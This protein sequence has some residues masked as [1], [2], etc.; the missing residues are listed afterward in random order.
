[1]AKVKE[2]TLQFG[3]P[4]RSRGSLNLIRNKY[5]TIAAKWPRKRGKAKSGYLFYR[6]WEFGIVSRWAAN[7]EPIARQ[8]ADELVKGTDLVWRDMFVQC[9]FGSLYEIQFQDGTPTYRYRDVVPNAQLMLDQVTDTIGSL[10]Y[11]AQ[12]GWVG[13]D[14]GSNNFV[15]TMRSGLPM[16]LPAQGGGGGGA[17]AELVTTLGAGTYIVDPTKTQ[18]QIIAIAGAG[19]GGGG[20][21]SA[22]ATACSGGGGGGGAAIVRTTFQLA[23][24]TGNISFVIG[25]GGGGGAGG[26]AINSNGLAGGAGT[27]TTFVVNGRTY[28]ASPG[29]GGVGGSTG[30]AGGG[31]ASVA[32]TDLGG[33]GGG[34]TAGAAGGSA[35]AVTTLGGTGGGAG[36][37]RT[38][39]GVGGNGGDAGRWSSAIGYPST[40]ALGGRVTPAALPQDGLLYRTLGISST[41]GGGG[42]G[43]T[44]GTGQ[45]GGAGGL[46]GGGGGGGA[47]STNGAP[48]GAGGAGGQGAILFIAT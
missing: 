26:A 25:G 18:L 27:A 6:Q 42:A 28:T 32:G 8:T 44:G 11:R 19:G 13:L 30:T 48:G 31:A 21:Q 12:I 9:S 29:G 20:R 15:L 7:P 35:P 46:F 3:A 17:V 36:S 41:G 4:A 16:W 1:M 37:G 43:S 45:A 2:G 33:A 39:T 34:V 14:P 38:N 23:D 47:A 22:A 24:I 10:V 5:G 40:V